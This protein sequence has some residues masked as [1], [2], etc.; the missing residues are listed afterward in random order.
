MPRDGSG[1]Y[2][3]KFTNIIVSNESTGVVYRKRYSDLIGVT[4]LIQGVYIAVSKKY[5][6][7]SKRR[8]SLSVEGTTNGRCQFWFCRGGE[9]N[10]TVHDNGPFGWVETAPA[11]P[12]QIHLSPGVQ[13]VFMLRITK[14]I[15]THKTRGN[16]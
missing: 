4:F 1:K 12:R 14:Q 3:D 16:T 10:M 6:L 8:V 15:A 7:R 9:K 11:R 2:S 13:L 5:K